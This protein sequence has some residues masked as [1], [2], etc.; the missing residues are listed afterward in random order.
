MQT[1]SLQEKK[2]TDLQGFA[3][4]MTLNK[5]EEDAFPKVFG[6]KLKKRN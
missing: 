6:T 4:N 1:E 3:S 5:L 2:Q